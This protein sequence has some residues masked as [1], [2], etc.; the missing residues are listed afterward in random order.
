MLWL[1]TEL[2][3]ERQ[4]YRRATTHVCCAIIG[5]NALMRKCQ[6]HPVSLQGIEKQKTG[7]EYTSPG[8]RRMIE[9]ERKYEVFAS[10]ILASRS[11]FSGISAFVD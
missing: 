11:Q 4:S 3:N 1:G 5:N 7:S 2:R 9:R 10:G 8:I 6:C